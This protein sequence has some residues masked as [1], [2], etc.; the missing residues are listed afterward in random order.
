LFRRECFESIGGYVPLKVGG[1]DLVAVT[2]ARMEGWKTKTFTEKSCEHHR[3]IG[4]AGT[5]G[6]KVAFRSGYHDYL[7]GV[8]AVWQFF[9]SVYQMRNKPYIT[10]GGALFAG[11]FWALITRPARPVSN[12]FVEFRRREQMKRLSNFFTKMLFPGCLRY[13]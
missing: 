12:E 13:P 8:H 1:I 9:R 2:T 7:M 4:T 3:K 11:Y 6:L 10:G 5:N